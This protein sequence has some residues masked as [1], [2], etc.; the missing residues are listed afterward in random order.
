M[1]EMFRDTSK[2]RSKVFFPILFLVLATVAQ[3]RLSSDKLKSSKRNERESLIAVLAK[4]LKIGILTRSDEYIEEAI[5]SVVDLD[6]ILG[7]RV[8]DSDGKVLRDI[9]KKGRPQPDIAPTIELFGKNL[10]SRL[11]DYETYM[12][13]A[14]PVY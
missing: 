6:D 10:A 7:V 11:F 1:T 5:K 3:W 14:A 8:Y 13:L 12:E 4:N 9:G 2:F